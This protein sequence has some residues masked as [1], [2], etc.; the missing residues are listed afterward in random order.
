MTRI[1]IIEDEPDIATPL[2]DDLELEGYHVEVTEDGETGLR[3]LAE[4]AFD[5]L[6]LDVMLP[7][8]DGFELCRRLR[9]QGSRLTIILLT[10]K[11]QEADKEMRLE[12]GDRV[13]HQGLEFPAYRLDHQRTDERKRLPHQL[14]QATH[15][16]GHVVQDDLVLLTQLVGHGTQRE[17]HGGDRILDLVSHDRRRLTHRRQCP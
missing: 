11:T 7:G 13:L 17:V 6:L 5:L 16:Q 1:L 15:P 14:L 3:R 9:R 10:A 12:L 4:S 2:R 8:I